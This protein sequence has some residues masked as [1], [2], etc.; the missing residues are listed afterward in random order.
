MTWPP[1]RWDGNA[2]GCEMISKKAY[3]LFYT[4]FL[5][6]EHFFTDWNMMVFFNISINHNSC[7]G[8]THMIIIVDWICSVIIKTM[9]EPAECPWTIITYSANPYQWFALFLLRLRQYWYHLSRV[10]GRHYCW[11]FN[12]FWIYL[13]PY[14]V[15]KLTLGSTSL[16]EFVVKRAGGYEYSS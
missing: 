5:P 8:T 1:W 7:P 16:E 13:H 11:L 15:G 6:H 12:V 10:V 3:E 2:S 4:F 9:M 14:G